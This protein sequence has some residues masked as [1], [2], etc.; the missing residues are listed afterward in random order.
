[1]LFPVLR[2]YFI[3]Y[4]PYYKIMYS[5]ILYFD[6]YGVYIIIPS[7]KETLGEK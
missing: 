5:Y 4:I 1:M 2:S 3:I 6:A 7:D